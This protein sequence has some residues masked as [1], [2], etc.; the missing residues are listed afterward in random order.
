M[1]KLRL[2]EAKQFTP[3]AE[4]V[5]GLLPKVKWGEPLTKQRLLLPVLGGIFPLELVMSH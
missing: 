3:V 2:K 1:K 5:H 4:P